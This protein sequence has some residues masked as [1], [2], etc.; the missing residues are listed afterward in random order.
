[1]TDYGEELGR[2]A[3]KL[4]EDLS[5]LEA[6]ARGKFRGATH[7]H[8][9]HKKLE[10]YVNQQEYRSGSPGAYG[11]GS[12]SGYGSPRSASPMRHHNRINNDE[13]AAGRSD[14]HSGR[15]MGR[16]A[17]SP[18]K[19]MPRSPM[20]SSTSEMVSPIAD[21][22]ALLASA[23]YNCGPA[24]RPPNFANGS[25]S[26]NKGLSVNEKLSPHS[27]VNK[28]NLP[29][30]LPKTYQYQGSSKSSPYSSPR[31][32]VSSPVL[33]PSRPMTVVN[34]IYDSSSPRS[35]SVQ[36]GS[37]SPQSSVIVHSD[38]SDPG[39]FGRSSYSSRDS[40]ADSQESQHASP[41]SSVSSLGRPID[42]LGRPIMQAKPQ[43]R[44][45]V[46]AAA[47]A[48]ERH[49]VHKARDD[50]PQRDVF[51]EDEERRPPR[52]PPQPVS[53]SHSTTSAYNQ[54]PQLQ[55]SV[56]QR[57]SR[58]AYGFTNG[59]S[60]LPPLNVLPPE[61]PLRPTS[62]S[63]ASPKPRLPLPYHI[64]PPKQKGPTEAEKKIAAITEQLENEMAGDSD[65][66]GE[67]FGK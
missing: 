7:G 22:P 28:G 62:H 65:E 58:I 10:M 3:T 55:N 51:Y 57:S 31:E 43:A 16:M 8:D 59:T 29:H 50:S 67:F 38:V 24:V 56:Q 1:M 39:P 19:V 45:N 27:S 21:R 46:A 52:H 61:S 37:S 66:E 11:S 12:P 34:H 44:S 36:S 33:S 30:F 41:R 47:A 26:A 14:M 49:L 54:P 64:T 23:R 6:E 40:S 18:V 42:A 32:S 20:D 9:F 53:L 13:F 25:T 63:P 48:Y 35:S 4:M 17:V 5:I 60:Q 2:E 15:P